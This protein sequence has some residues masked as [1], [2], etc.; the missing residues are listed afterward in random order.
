MMTRRSYRVL[1]IVGAVAV[2]ALTV[3]LALTPRPPLVEVVEGPPVT[4][5]MGAPSAPPPTL[6][7]GDHEPAVELPTPPD[8]LPALV[9][10]IAIVVALLLVAHFI[11]RVLQ[12]QRPLERRTADA[13]TGEAVEVAD[14]DEEELAETLSEAVTQLRRG[15]AVESAIVECWLRLEALAADSGI[16]RRPSQTSEEFT[17]EVLS[18][19]RVDEGALASLGSLYRQ[20][21]FSTHTLTDADRDRAI[22]SL[23]AVGEQLKVTR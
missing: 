1:V 12:A 5:S 17:V 3:L 2:V 10:T 11:R 16:T 23:L 21:L 14:V 6:P 18:R 13:P 20:A 4:I 9:R 15:I 8:W 22:D 19:T 7:M